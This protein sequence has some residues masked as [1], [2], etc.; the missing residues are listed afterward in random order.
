M[1]VCVCVRFIRAIDQAMQMCAQAG[2]AETA[3]EVRVWMRREG[4]EP[5]PGS[6]AV[7]R[8]TQ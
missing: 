3:K 7:Y 2:D 4:L 1:C 5:M 8:E 6:A